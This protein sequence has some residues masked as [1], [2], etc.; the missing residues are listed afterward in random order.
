MTSPIE[1]IFEKVP[2]K[3]G[4]QVV[5][6]RL[7][8]QLDESNVDDKA[9]QVYLFIEDNPDET[10]YIFELSDLEYMNSKS[11]GYLTDWYRKIT[12]KAGLVKLAQAKENILDILD[13]VG[14]TSIIEHHSNM[15]SAM[16]AIVGLD[17]E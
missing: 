13:T 17:E 9:K 5:K 4:H 7:V 6:V 16:V 1:L 15:D 8:G 14:L 12:N 10:H 3:T 11:I 2:C